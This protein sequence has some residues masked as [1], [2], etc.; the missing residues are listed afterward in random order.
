MISKNNVEVSNTQDK[1]YTNLLVG[2]QIVGWKRFFDVQAPYRWNLQ[3][4]KPG[5]TLDIGCGIGRNLINLKGKG[6]GIDHNLNSVQVARNLGLTAFTPEEFQNS[7]F[8]T[9]QRFD[10]LLLSHVAEHMNQKKVS[11]L[12]REYI[13]LLKPKG[14]LIIITPQEAGYKSDPT[15]VEFMDFLKLCNIT[16]QLGFKVLKEYSFPFPRVVGHFFMFNEFISVSCRTH[17]A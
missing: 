13:T 12:L 8:N 15:H 17:M 11:E 16:S 2:K 9:S 10:S 7:H 14:K 1:E 5:L 3:Q 4:L 6:I